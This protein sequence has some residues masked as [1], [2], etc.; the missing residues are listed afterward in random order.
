MRGMRRGR[1][2]RGPTCFSAKKGPTM[3]PPEGQSPMNERTITVKGQRLRIA[4]RSGDGTCMPL[5][6]MNGL[7]ANLELLQPFVDALAP[8]IEVICFDVPGVGGSPPPAIPY[9]FAT[10]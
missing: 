2:R 6:L 3:Q 5:L 4:T 10:L 1:R 9:R 8:A 7:G